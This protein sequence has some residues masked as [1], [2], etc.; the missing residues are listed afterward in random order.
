MNLTQQKEI[1]NLY[2]QYQDIEQ[3]TIKANIK[4]Y[5]DQSNIKPSKLSQ[6]T[7]IPIQ[8]IYQL[9]KFNNPYKPD[10]MTALIICDALRISITAVLIPLED[11]SQL[12]TAPKKSK[13]TSN[14]K[15][16][17]IT[18]Y[19]SLPIT[20]LCEKYSITARTAGEYNR[21]FSDDLGI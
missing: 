6:L 1:I 14:A 8:T 9:R 5:M 21:V 15:Q 17:F 19:N 20:E 10:F 16:R 2:T 12:I 13:W 4:Q 7:T 3:N 18:D 11:N